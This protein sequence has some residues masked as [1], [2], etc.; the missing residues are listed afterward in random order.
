[1]TQYRIPDEPLPSRWQHLA[2]QPF[3]PLLS[4]ML[5]GC[6]M[7]WPWL[8]VNAK[9]MGSPTARAEIRLCLLGFLG[10]AV[11]GFVLLWVVGS[12]LVQDKLVVELLLVALVVWRLGV[13]YWVVNL[14][15]RTFHLYEHYGGTVR[16]GLYVV[17][18]GMLGRSWVLGLFDGLLWPIVV[19]GG[20]GGP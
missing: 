15:S 6:W 14:Q 18:G 11:Y 3:W 12:G 10:S 5:A 13:T 20:L 16:S 17:L 1:M 19:G 8:M 7:A 9:A 4:V 2:V